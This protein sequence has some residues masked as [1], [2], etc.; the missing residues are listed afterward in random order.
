MSL[1][2]SQLHRVTLT[3]VN[4][5]ADAQEA[6][7]ARIRAGKLHPSIHE[8][9]ARYRFVGALDIAGPELHDLAELHIDDALALEGPRPAWPSSDRRAW[10][11]RVVSSLIERWSQ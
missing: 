5:A 10:T 1:T 11:A 6:T 2:P 9:T 8:R 7:Q 3:L 4:L